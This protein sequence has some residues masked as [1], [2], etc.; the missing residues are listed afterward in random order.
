MIVTTFASPLY[1]LRRRSDLPRWLSRNRGGLDHAP[2]ART[3]AR[4]SCRESEGRLDPPACSLVRMAVFCNQRRIRLPAPYER[5]PTYDQ[6]APVGLR[7][8]CTGR[9]ADPWTK[10]AP[11]QPRHVPEPSPASPT[12]RKCASYAP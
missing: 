9:L 7:G 12:T 4:A 8:N 3:A 1:F 5:C 10:W 6:R 2:R 11:V